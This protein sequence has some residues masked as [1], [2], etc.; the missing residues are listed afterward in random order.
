MET[1]MVLECPQCGEQRLH[2]GTPSSD[3]LSRAFALHLTQ[4]HPSLLPMEAERL[5]EQ[6]ISS[7]EP[8]TVDG[9][10]DFAMGHWDNY[11]L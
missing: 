4:R 9:E 3:Q 10:T 6:A 11:D 2:R 8:A 1:Y 7:V 5:I